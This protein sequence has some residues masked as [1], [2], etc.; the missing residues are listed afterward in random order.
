MKNA[1]IKAYEDGHRAERLAAAY[2]RLK[3]YRILKMRYKTPVGEVD[4]IARRGKNLVMVE[5]KS[6]A[7]KAS[8]LES[9]TTKNQAR[10]MQA[11][12]YFLAQNQGYMH[13]DL[14]FDVIVTGLPF[15]FQHLDNAWQEHT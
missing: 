9:V 5:V 7:G 12:Q 1:K 10:V 2:L 13:L 11:A 8:A 3:G 15:F 14:R 6:R 4:I